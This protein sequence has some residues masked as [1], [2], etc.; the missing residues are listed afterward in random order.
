V[1]GTGGGV[2]GAACVLFHGPAAQSVPFLGG[3]LYVA[4]PWTR[5]AP[6][7]LDFVG[8]VAYS[9]PITAAE[10]GT[11]RFFQLWFSDPGDAFGVGLS[12]GLQLY[13]CP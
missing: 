1:I 2:P 6:A 8:G 10:V 7:T 12:N 4:G 13:F 3:T 5:L 11:R 9:I